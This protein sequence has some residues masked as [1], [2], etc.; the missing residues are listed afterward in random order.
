MRLRNILL[1]A[2]LLSP[3]LV[4][5]A[6]QPLILEPGSTL[7]PP[8]IEVTSSRPAG[9][10]IEFSLPALEVEEL[11][12]DGRDFQDVSIPGGGAVGEIGQPAIPT[13]TRLIMIPD[14]SGVRITPVVTDEVELEGYNLVPLQDYDDR[15]FMYD[16][17]AYQRG[18]FGDL[19]PAEVGDPAIM[20]GMRVVPLTFQPVRYNAAEGVLRVARSINVEV[21]FEGE[22][23]INA[24]EPSVMQIAPS[25]DRIYQHLVI[26]YEGATAEAE[27]TPGSWVI[28]CPNNSSV[29]TRLQDLVDWRERKGY[30]VRLATTSETGTSRTQ[31][32]SWMQTQYNTMD[33]PP[34]YFVLAGDASG[35][36]SI[37]TWYEST[38]GYSGEGDH[39]YVQLEGGDILADAH[40]GRLSFSDLDELE[41]IVDKIVGYESTPELSSSSWYKRACIVGDPDP[42]GYSCI[43]V[44][45]WLKSRLRDHHTYTDIDTVFS[46]SWVTQIR[47]SLNQGGTIF[48]YR[49]YYGMSGWQ[50]S[51]TYALT[52]GMKMPFAVVITC[53][54]GS[55]A[56]GTSRSEGFLRAHSG[57]SPRGGIASVGTSTIGTHTRYNNCMAYGIFYGL[58]WEDQWTLGA[59]LTRGKLE[60]YLNYQNHEPSKVTIWSHWNNLMGDPAV[61]CWTGYPEEL[62]VSHPSEVPVGTNSI[63][64]TVQNHGQPEENAQVCL[65]KDGETHVVGF[66]DSDGILELPV[67]A[68]GTG[69]ILLTITKHDRHPYLATIR[70]VSENVYV[71][72]FSHGI[73]DDSSGSSSG[74]GDSVVN[75]GETIELSVQLKNF[76]SQTASSV[77][78]TLACEDPYVTIMDASESFGTIGG[79]ST[80]WSSDDFDLQIDPECPH[81]RLIR[82]S[83]DVSSGGDYWHSMID[84]PVVSADLVAT[85]VTLHNAGGNGIWDPDE[86]I[87]LG[88]KI[89]NDGGASAT[90]VTG[91]LSSQSSKIS[92]IDGSGSWGTISIGGQA[93]NTSNLFTLRAASDTYEGFLAPFE[94]V[95]TYS[96]GLNDTTTFTVPVGDVSTDD[97]VGP[98]SYGYHAFDNTDTSYPEAPDYAWIE[99]DPSYG[100]S[101]SEIPLSDYGTYQDDS[102]VID[103]PFQFYYYGEAF[104]KAT[105]CSNGWIAMG[106]T[107]LTQYRNWAL[108]AAG[109]PDGI[110]A[111]FWDDLRCHS[112]G[113]VYQYYDAANNRFI[114]EWS[115]LRNEPGSTQTVQVILY[116]PAHHATLTGD[117]M[118]DMQFHT[119]NDTDS[120]DNYCTVGIESP[121]SQDGLTYLYAD[122][123]APGAATVQSGRAVRF[124]PIAE[125]PSGTIT[126]HVWN[127][128]YGMLP[129]PEAVITVQG[130]GRSF[131]SGSDGSYSGSVPP[132]FYTVEVTHVGF[133]TVTVPGIGIVV[134]EETVQNFQMIDNAG[135]ILTTTTHETTDDTIGPYP[136]PVT[137]NEYSGIIEKTL[138]YTTDGLSI[139]ELELVEQGGQEYLAAIPGQDY[140]KIV[141]YWIQARDFLGHISTDPPGAPDEKFSFFVRPIAMSFDDDVESDLGWTI[142]G[143]DDDATTGVW[144]RADPSGTAA[145]MEDD[146]TPDGTICFVTDGRGGGQGD[147]D[148]DDGK[149]TL[150]SP[151]FD[152]SG[153]G[154]AQLSYYRWY[155]NDTGSNPGTDYWVVQLTDDDGGSW[156]TIENTNEADRSWRLMEF[157][158]NDYIDMTDEVRIRFIASDESP[159]SIVEAGVDDLVLIQSSIPLDP[160]DIAD[161]SGEPARFYLMPSRPNPCHGGVTIAF[162]LANEA[163][164]QLS[165]Y[166]VTGRQVRC[167]ISGQCPAGVQSVVWDGRDNRGA[168]AP[169][170]IYFYRLDA[171]G[172]SDVQKLM[173]IQ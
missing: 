105:V 124:L 44:G 158:L 134:G 38:S 8:R 74:N 6:S 82:L 110:L 40:I 141:S 19:A 162:S 36:Y 75:P 5:A 90:S 67:T 50:N 115:R 98:D 52:N 55:F 48:S 99:I 60:M 35:T 165:V 21:S 149:T 129:I 104:T 118:I 45:Q 79:G 64:V 72:Y 89:R 169:S 148:V 7:E 159:G 33:P 43:Q 58:L 97:P 83:V 37:P 85:G 62:S 95:T 14:R 23:L 117:G 78:A 65:L 80:A 84:L 10:D 42:S 24:K 77:T 170:G 30:N 100:G 29:T 66:T 76:G 164:A 87:D 107:Y 9:L 140:T 53:D 18:G 93:E 116:D 46:G 143:P 57:G 51:N 63:T 152:L 59:A 142:G 61:D 157:T 34:E 25:F 86:T 2:C 27:M 161:S 47:N 163:D 15:P 119:V 28:I 172:R 109:G 137:I 160:A 154:A 68:E 69:D 3:T 88:V 32:Q 70:V 156:V 71:G 151:M 112:G 121:D 39:P 111:V 130:T 146:H 16:A 81:G 12:L 131:V 139:H 122:D 132:G 168:I 108:P 136:I 1:F 135:P 133:E 113:K 96:G 26:N 17:Q 11:R 41:V 114:V 49:G 91:I 13:F 106:S 20:R 153:G 31:I 138:F 22:N 103:L 123:H 166:D 4:L 171:E 144:E 54:T 73:D 92:I 120:G 127:E 101:G 147:Y 125:L 150:T 126:G 56:E 102:I 94:L 167:L 155:S 173:R 128:S 145:Q